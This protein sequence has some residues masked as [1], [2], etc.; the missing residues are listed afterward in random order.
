VEAL[1]G[2]LCALESTFERLKPV[3]KRE[4]GATANVLISLIDHMRVVAPLSKRFLSFEAYAYHAH[5]R[6]ALDER[7]DESAR[8]YRSV[9]HFEKCLEVNEAIGDAGGIATAKTYIAYATSYKS[10][11][12]SGNNNEELLQASQELYE[13]SVDKFGEVNE[14]T[15]RVGEFHDI[16]LRKVNRGGGEARDLLS[17]LLATSKQV[18]VNELKKVIG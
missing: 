15:I 6:I 12:N 8:S 16:E 3:Q 2:K 1:Q 13:V 4:V 18:L 11:N 7:T 14:L 9:A 10:G 5:G 17:K